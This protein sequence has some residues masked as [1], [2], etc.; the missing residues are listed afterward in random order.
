[1][2]LYDEVGMPATERRLPGLDGPRS[3]KRYSGGMK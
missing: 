3:T 1:M 2:D